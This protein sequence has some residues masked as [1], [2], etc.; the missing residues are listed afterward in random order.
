M[1]PPIDLAIRAAIDHHRAGRLGEAELLYRQVLQQSPDHA[2]AIQYLGVIAIQK[3]QLDT[4]VELISRAISLSPANSAYHCNLANALREGGQLDEA[5]AS[6]RRAISLNPQNATAQGSLGST[7]LRQGNFDEA[8]ESL[9][10]A[11]DFKP[12]F[13]EAWFDLATSLEKCGV[14]NEALIGYRNVV[15]LKPDWIAAHNG[16]GKALLKL[17]RPAE[18]LEIFQKAIHL[19]P[20]EPGLWYN[21]GSAM[22]EMGRMA[23][24]LAAFRKCLSL[25]PR[26][27]DAHNNVAFLLENEGKI[28]ESVR[29]YRLAAENDPQGPVFHS[30]LVYALSLSAEYDAFAILAE[31]RRWN[32]SHGKPARTHRRPHSNLRDPERRLKVGYASPDLRQHVVGWNLLPLLREHDHRLFE[33]HCY[34]SAVHGS[35]QMTRKIR[36]LSDQWRDVLSLSDEQLAEQIRADGIDVLIDLSLHTSHNRLRVFAMEPAPVQVTYLG[37][38]G[39]SGVQGMHYRFSDPYLDPPGDDLSCYSEKTARLAKTYWCY[40]PHPNSPEVSELPATKRGQ[41]TFGGMNQLK[42]VSSSAV[43][44]WSEILA[45]VPNSRLLMH[46]P[47]GAGRE[48]IGK[49]LADRGIAPDRVEFVGQLPWEQYI[50]CYHRIDLAVDTFPFGGGITTCDAVWM[51]VPLVTLSGRTSVGRAG[52][53]I[54]SNVGISELIAQNEREYVNLAVE[55]ATD[56][57]R[58]AEYRQTLRQ[59]MKASALLDGRGFAREVEGAY[60]RMWRDWCATA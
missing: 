26:N 28:D 59:K 50:S 37:Y 7:L 27:A 9:R 42:K 31:A 58:L 29:E 30:N 46:A 36:E 22:K 23:D 41:V 20:Y 39:T 32:E 19:K 49:K 53:S 21:I 43:D 35:D 2:D 54:L 17:K 10:R 45:R 40:E 38:S 1:Q 6:Y 18:A 25:D 24:A 57:P 12:D 48:W 4:A 47:P 33:I 3:G 52:T 44:L 16:V 13:V 14:W 5:I 51:G 11:V 34:Y 60:R 8:I 56:L 55:L 15:R